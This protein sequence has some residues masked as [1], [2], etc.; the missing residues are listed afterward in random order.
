MF[1]AVQVICQ[2]GRIRKNYVAVDD[3]DAFSK[4]VK[5]LGGQLLMEP[6]DVFEDGKM[7]VA[8]DPA[9]AAFGIW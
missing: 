9:G 2:A 1:H 5:D 6:F 7:A 4:K 3:A 8:Q